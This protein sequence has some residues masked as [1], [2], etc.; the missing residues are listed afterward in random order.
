MD[1]IGTALG[2]V[3]TV[4]GIAGIACSYYF[5]RKS[6]QDSRALR[7]HQDRLFEAAGL[8][9]G[10]RNALMR[11]PIDR[12]WLVEVLGEE[13]A[14]TRMGKW[15]V[16]ESKKPISEKNE[17]AMMWGLVQVRTWLD[18]KIEA[19]IEDG[20]GWWEPPAPWFDD[21]EEEEEEDLQKVEGESFDEA[22]NR[23]EE[24]ESKRWRSDDEGS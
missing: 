4:L 19:E 21:Y 5:Y 17:L 22:M 15:I 2:I 9:P 23:M 18:T 24:E 3:G 12:E 20:P 1:D 7:E 6:A 11:G 13:G 10:Q 14:D 16:E 8:N